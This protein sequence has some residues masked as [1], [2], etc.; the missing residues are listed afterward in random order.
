MKD[1]KVLFNFKRSMNTCTQAHKHALLNLLVDVDV[2]LASSG[3]DVGAV[4]GTCVRKV[5]AGFADISLD[6]VETRFNVD[7]FVEYPDSILLDVLNAL[8]VDGLIKFCGVIYD[9]L[10]DVCN[11]DEVDTCI[12][13]KLV[14]VADDVT[15][16]MDADVYLLDLCAVD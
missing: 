1:I 12:V 10:E 16:K 15:L 9:K 13:D 14:Y 3:V 5:C 6:V 8:N 4:K 11:D 2:L 7:D